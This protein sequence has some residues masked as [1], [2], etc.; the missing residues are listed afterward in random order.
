[1]LAPVP[2]NLLLSHMQTCALL[3]KLNCA[4]P[5]PRMNPTLPHHCSQSLTGFPANPAFHAHIPSPPQPPVEECPFLLPLPSPTMDWPSWWLP[6]GSPPT[7]THLGFTWELCSHHSCTVTHAASLL[8]RRVRKLRLH[9][10]KISSCH[11]L[12]SLLSSQKTSL[13]SDASHTAR[14]GPHSDPCLPTL[15]TA[16]RLRHP[17]HLS[18]GGCTLAS[19]ESQQ[20]PLVKS[21]AECG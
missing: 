17:A 7:A 12:G 14:P 20:P 9:V 13:V 8:L 11:N 2:N 5:G 4:S 3:P 10:G 16:A 1:M 21:R 15:F 19:R 6:Q 18:S